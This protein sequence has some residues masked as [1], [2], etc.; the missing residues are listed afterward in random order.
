MFALQMEESAIRRHH[1][2]ATSSSSLA[3]PAIAD[4]IIPRVVEPETAP[5]VEEP[6]VEE[7]SQLV[8]DPSY[9]VLVTVLPSSV[10]GVRITRSS[11]TTGGR[12]GNYDRIGVRCPKSSTDHA[13]AAACFKFRNLGQGQTSRFGPIEAVGYLGVWLSRRAEFADKPAHMKF[14]PTASAV[15][16][17]LEKHG[18]IRHR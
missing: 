17:Y 13:A 10:E 1:R 2:P 15:C 18:F 6:P 11:H 14:T 8:G 12:T 3:P 16:E 5:I 7:E 4:S 9:E